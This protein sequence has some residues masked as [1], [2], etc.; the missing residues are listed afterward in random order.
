[1]LVHLQEYNLKHAQFKILPRYK[2]KTEGEAVQLFDQIICESVKSPGQYFHASAPWKID[3]FSIGS[4]LNLGI[5]PAG[6]TVVK[7]YRP[8]E[9]YKEYL[10][11]GSVIRL[12]HKE[13][14]AFLVAE[15]LFDEEVTEDGCQSSA[16]PTSPRVPRMDRALPLWMAIER[17]CRR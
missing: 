4:E 10:R 1:M 7:S 15:G 13:L 11:G 2:V 6:F 12:F 9:E 3:N 17:R 16:P 5:Q 8:S 14:E